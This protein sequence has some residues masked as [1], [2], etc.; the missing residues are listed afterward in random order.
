MSIGTTL[1]NIT[2]YIAYVCIILQ[3]FM[4]VID[5]F[6]KD[7]QIVNGSDNNLNTIIDHVV[8]IGNKLLPPENRSRSGP[9]SHRRRK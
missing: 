1:W 8:D 4:M 9:A 3:T 2:E 7:M 5:Y 6:T